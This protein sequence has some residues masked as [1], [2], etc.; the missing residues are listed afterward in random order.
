MGDSVPKATRN[1]MEFSSRVEGY[2]GG[3]EMIA[4]AEGDMV[5]AVRGFKTKLSVVF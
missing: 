5:H 1:G 2:K 3:L 4:Q